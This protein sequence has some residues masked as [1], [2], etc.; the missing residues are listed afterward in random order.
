MLQS[1]HCPSRRLCEACEG[2]MT[3]SAF[4]KA[5]HDVAW[6]ISQPSAKMWP[7]C[8]GLVVRAGAWGNCTAS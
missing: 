6:P 3:A 2:F 7:W 4:A 5:G 8:Q 1:L